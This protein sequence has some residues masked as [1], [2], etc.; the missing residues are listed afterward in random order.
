MNATEHMSLCA[1]LDLDLE[2]TYAVMRGLYSG[3]EIGEALD[4]MSRDVLDSWRESLRLV[5]VPKKSRA[6]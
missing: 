1:S 2:T 3:D 6:F 5:A 4:S